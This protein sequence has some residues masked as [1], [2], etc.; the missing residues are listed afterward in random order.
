V[1]G[2]PPATLTSE[3]DPG[4]ESDDRKAASADV[5]LATDRAPGEVSAGSQLGSGAICGAIP[6]G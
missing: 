4:P 1:P 3:D 2:Q 6:A 5:P